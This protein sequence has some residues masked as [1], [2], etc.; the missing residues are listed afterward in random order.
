MAE[1]QTFGNRIGLTNHMQI[2]QLDSPEKAYTVLVNPSS[3]SVSHATCF[4]KSQSIQGTETYYA[5]NKVKPQSMS[6]ELLFD[7]TG[8][9]GQIPFNGNKS[10]LDQIND[11]FDIALI[12]D[13]QANENG[14]KS[15]VKQLQLIWG[16]M[17]FDG[18]LESVDIN[19]SHFD[20]T[21]APIRAKAT[22]AFSG[23]IFRF[24]KTPPVENTTQEKPRKVVDYSKQKHAINAVQKH[25]S[26]IA[27]VSQQPKKA[28][29]KSLRIAEEVA[30]MIIR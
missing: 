3:Y 12:R 26:Y 25:G 18:V 8:S 17:E 13:A 29:P 30:K 28:L 19:Y 7:S 24:K 20:P 6:L 21:G 5:F 9:L 15:T 23:G 2:R 22:C 11:F 10:V 16:S 4:D 27:I 1:S 14:E